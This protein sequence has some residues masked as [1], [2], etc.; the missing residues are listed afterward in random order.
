MKPKLVIIILL[1]LFSVQAQAG[2][3]KLIRDLG[4][5]I[6]ASLIA[7]EI[8][9]SQSNQVTKEIT[10]R[11]AVKYIAGNNETPYLLV[12]ANYSSVVVPQSYAKEGSIVLNVSSA[13]V[14]DMAYGNNFMS[15]TARFSGVPIRIYLPNGSINAVY[16]K[17]TGH[18]FS[19]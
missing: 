19:L 16:A 6:L 18:G 13:A 9:A 8:E 10:I 1:V 12:N 7:S 5:G 17:E 15:F 4:L 2:K 14:T 11:S 3:G